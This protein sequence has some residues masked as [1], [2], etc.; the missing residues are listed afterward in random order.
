MATTIGH[1]LAKRGQVLGLYSEVFAQHAAEECAVEI[2]S[3][4]DL[5]KLKGWLE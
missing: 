2:L 4:S 1:I 5:K 3:G